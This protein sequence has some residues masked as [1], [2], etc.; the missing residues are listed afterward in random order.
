MPGPARLT[1]RYLR[2]SVVA[3]ALLL[4]VAIGLDVLAGGERF[5][6]ISGYFYSPVRSVFV[7]SLV[8]I[9]PALVAIK[10]RAGWEDVLLDLAGMVVPV[11]AFV[12]ARQELGPD[13][14]G[15]IQRCIPPDLVGAVGNN[16]A[17]LIVLGVPVLVFAWWTGLRG[18]A[19]AVLAGL[20]SATVAYLVLVV[21]FV[22]W[23]GTFLAA[24]HDV[25]AV[26]FFLLIAAVAWLNGRRAPERAQARVLTPVRFAHAYRAIAGVMVATLVVTLATWVLQAAGALTAPFGSVFVAETLL[27]V[28]FIAFWLLQTAE[29][30]DQEAA[31]LQP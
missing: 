1:Y 6:S 24:G 31:T 25:A 7:G 19:P 13:V 18:G 8:A 22:V 9:G 3:M 15:G 16:V 17:A 26:A 11:V 30:W 23:R 12:P 20:V 14:C 4:F 21:W 5:G 10:G 2:V 28:A 29:N 27:L